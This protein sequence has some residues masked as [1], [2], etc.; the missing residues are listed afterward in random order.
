MFAQVQIALDKLQ[1][2]GD[3]AFAY[4]ASS[5]YLSKFVG[6]MGIVSNKCPVYCLASADFYGRCSLDK[7]VVEIAGR[8]YVKVSYPYQ[9]PNSRSSDG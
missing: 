5:L 6:Q 4:S 1:A 7:Q 2:S 3:V 8:S 9:P